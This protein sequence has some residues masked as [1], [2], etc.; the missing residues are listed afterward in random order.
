MNTKFLIS[1]SIAHNGIS[2]VVSNVF[3]VNQE[4]DVFLKV[5]NVLWLCRCLE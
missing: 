4:Y 5:L 3:H 1:K 2:V